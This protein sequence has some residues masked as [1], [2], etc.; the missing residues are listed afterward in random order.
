MLAL[1]WAITEKF[2][3]YLLGSEFEVF[4]DNNPLSHLQTA[5]L[6]AVEQI[7]AA[8]LALFKFKI[9]YPPGRANANAYPLSRVARGNCE[10]QPPREDDLAEVQMDEINV[11]YTESCQ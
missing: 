2:R 11:R 10:E 5:K 7:W 1:K 8:E 3:S 4:T 6:R 9:K